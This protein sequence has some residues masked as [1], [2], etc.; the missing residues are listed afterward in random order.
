M[1]VRPSYLYLL[2]RWDFVF[3][4]LKELH[5]GTAC[6]PLIHQNQLVA[7]YLHKN[8]PY[9]LYIMLVGLQHSARLS[10]FSIENE[11]IG[12]FRIPTDTMS[13]FGNVGLCTLNRLLQT[14]LF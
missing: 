10:K 12:K 2:V 7:Q 6:I 1:V 14:A 8:Q 5:I 13:A 9:M 11:V 3:V 4:N